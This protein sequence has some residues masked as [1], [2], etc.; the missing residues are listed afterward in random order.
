MYNPARSPPSSVTLGK[1]SNLIKCLFLGLNGAGLLTIDFFT[2]TA[3]MDRHWYITFLR[4]V[5][6]HLEKEPVL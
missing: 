1:Q 2:S 3:M 5:A 4:R 6:I